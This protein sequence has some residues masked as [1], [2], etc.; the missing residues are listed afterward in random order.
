[1]RNS[2]S[3]FSIMVICGKYNWLFL[4]DK[5]QFCETLKT[6]VKLILAAPCDYLYELFFSRTALR[7]STT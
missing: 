4:H 2:E 6:R 5:L 7:G 3:K 1:M